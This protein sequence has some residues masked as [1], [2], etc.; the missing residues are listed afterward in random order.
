[1]DDTSKTCTK[2]QQSK[3]LTEFNRRTTSGHRRF[4]WCKS[5]T[6]AAGKTPRGLE[7]RKERRSR[8]L[9]LRYAE[10]DQLKAGPCVDCGG[11]FPPIC[12][13]FDHVS[14]VKLGNVSM[15]ARDGVRWDLVLEEISKCEI[16]C[17][18]CHRIRTAS[19]R[20]VA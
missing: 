1:M 19:K 20:Q 3:P 7:R 9:R 13:D 8:R 4:S 5:C 15:M 14:G 2:C 6:L 10:L 16:V 17:A 11:R 12:M 18:N